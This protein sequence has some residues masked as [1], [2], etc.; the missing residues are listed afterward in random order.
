MLHIG[1]TF[2]KLFSTGQEA[3]TEPQPVVVAPV[4]TSI[5]EGGTHLLREANR[6]GIGGGV[7]AHLHRHTLGGMTLGQLSR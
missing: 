5:V 3:S 4:G 1:V 7:A 6:F 2:G